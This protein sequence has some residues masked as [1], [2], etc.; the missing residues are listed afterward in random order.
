MLHIIL[1][2]SLT[3]IHYIT[4]ALTMG[5]EKGSI[6]LNSTGNSEFYWKRIVM[7]TSSKFKNGV[8]VSDLA[9]QYMAKSTI[10]TFLKDKDR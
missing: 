2:A 4:A 6:L 3:L 9:M 8:R 10:L 7:R 5:P 1:R